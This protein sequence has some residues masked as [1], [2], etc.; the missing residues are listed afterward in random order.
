VDD[1]PVPVQTWV[2]ELDPESAPVQERPMSC[3]VAAPAPGSHRLRQV[4]WLA[5]GPQSAGSISW[6]Q[7]QP[8]LPVMMSIKAQLEEV[9]DVRVNP[10]P[11]S[12]AKPR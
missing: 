2:W 12:A 4:F 10:K 3:R 5:L 1:A 9:R 7:G 8:V 6:Q 11:G